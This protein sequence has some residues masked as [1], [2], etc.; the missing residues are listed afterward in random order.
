MPKDPPIEKF[1]LGERMVIKHIVLPNGTS[2]AWIHYYDDG[3]KRKEIPDKRVVGRGTNF[4]S[5]TI[6]AL[7]KLFHDEHQKRVCE[8]GCDIYLVPASE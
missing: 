1:E 2:E 8:S 3:V 5:A 6:D 7:N 4:E